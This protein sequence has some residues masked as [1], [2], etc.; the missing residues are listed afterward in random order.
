MSISHKLI[1]TLASR[2]PSP[3][4]DYGVTLLLIGAMTFVRYLAPDYVAP[5]LLFIPVLL[6]ASL[7]SA[8]ARGRSRWRS[9]P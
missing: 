1:G 4:V 5:F 6:V 7:R 2:R 8:A 3:A 9:P